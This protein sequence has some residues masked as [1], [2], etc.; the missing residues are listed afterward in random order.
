M[1]FIKDIG[2][3]NSRTTELQDLWQKI[4][5]HHCPLLS[6]LNKDGK[7]GKEFL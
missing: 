4:L 3:E 6:T 2:T 7:G 1:G 5:I